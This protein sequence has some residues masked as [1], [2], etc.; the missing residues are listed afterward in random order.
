MMEWGGEIEH[1][2]AGWTVWTGLGIDIGE[3]HRS[4]ETASSIWLLRQPR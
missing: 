2:W 1:G 4:H 3:E